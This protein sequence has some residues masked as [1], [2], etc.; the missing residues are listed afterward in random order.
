MHDGRTLP[1]IGASRDSV[2]QQAAIPARAVVPEKRRGHRRAGTGVPDGSCRQRLAA[3]IRSRPDALARWEHR[4][5]GTASR[6]KRKRGVDVP[7][8]VGR[9][10]PRRH[11]H[12]SEHERGDAEDDQPVRDVTHRCIDARHGP[13]SVARA[14]GGP[15]HSLLVKQRRLARSSADE[16]RTI[17]L[18]S[19]G[20][21]IGR[22]VEFGGRMRGDTSMKCDRRGG[23]WRRAGSAQRMSRWRAV[24]T[25]AV[26]EPT[27]SLP[28]ILARWLRTVP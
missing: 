18:V 8:I 19:P 25:A 13:T 12:Q 22:T 5:H 10:K 15:W 28:K 16:D 27:S 14:T 17:L 2:A 9:Y 4:G 6:R 3:S 21:H 23:E 20:G 26:R 1:E 24:A 11:H 7:T